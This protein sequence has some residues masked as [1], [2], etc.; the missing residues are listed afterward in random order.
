MI[1]QRSWPWKVKVIGRNKWHHQIPWPQKL[2]SRHQNRHP[3]RLSSKVMAKDVFLH[4]GGQR[5]AF[6][7]V[8]RSN[9]SRYFYDLL[10]GPDRSYPVIKFGDNLSRRNRDMAQSVILYNCDLE[11]SR[12]SVRSIIFCTAIRILPMSIH[13]KFYWDPTAVSLE[14]LRI[15]WPKVARRKKKEEERRTLGETVWRTLTLCDANYTMK[16]GSDVNVTN[17]WFVD[18]SLNFH[19]A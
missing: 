11:R 13:A 7:Y 12:S 19:L 14:N 9:R 15:I 10:K 4:N 5:N 3:K 6:A 17:T 8:S 1:S 18:L 16:D 2:I